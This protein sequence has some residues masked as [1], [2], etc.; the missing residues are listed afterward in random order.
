MVFPSGLTATP[1]ARLSPWPSA[2]GRAPEPVAVGARP[3]RL[4]HAAGTPSRLCDR[5]SGGVAVEARH[6][7][8][9]ARGDI[10]AF[11]VRAYRHRRRVVE[12]ISAGARHGP[13]PPIS[14]AA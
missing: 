4:T 2:H 11:S 5:P 7:T 6:G 3:S 1:A 8:A 13:R 9:V 10:D 12:P 14:H